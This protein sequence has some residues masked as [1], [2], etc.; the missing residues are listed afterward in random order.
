[1]ANLQNNNMADGQIRYF[2]PSK[3][4]TIQY[5]G[6]WTTQMI[7]ANVTRLYSSVFPLCLHY[8]PRLVTFL[9]IILNHECLALY[10]VV[11]V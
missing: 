4:P 10:A 6:L 7:H 1:M 5:T 8:A 3:F 11:T 2:P 9:T